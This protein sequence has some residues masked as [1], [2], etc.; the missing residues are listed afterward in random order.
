VKPLKNSNF[1]ENK[2]GT[3]L[4]DALLKAAIDRP[5]VNIN[6]HNNT[7]DYD[8]SSYSR[9]NNNS[10]IGLSSMT[11]EVNQELNDIINKIQNVE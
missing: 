4:K 7:K 11:A 1:L 3:T 5:F 10:K 6:V 2:K 9:E 8:D